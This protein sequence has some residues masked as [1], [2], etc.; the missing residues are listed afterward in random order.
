MRYLIVIEQTA[1]GYSAYSPDLDGCI[2]T[3]QT[4]DEVEQNMR[5]AIEFHLKGLRDE[6]YSVLSPRSYSTFVDVTI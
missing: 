1:T 6:G 5:E 2:A 4:K 3:G